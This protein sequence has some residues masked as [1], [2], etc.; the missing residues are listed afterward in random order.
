MADHAG[1]YE[2]SL[3]MA[4]YP[5]LVETSRLGM[6]PPW[7]SM[8]S[9]SKASKAT[10]EDGERLWQAMVSAWIDQ[11]NALTRPKRITPKDV[12]VTGIF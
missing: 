6:N 10:V 1:F 9:D 12:T 4:A 5:E 7:Y 8:T 3:V 11:L 2:T